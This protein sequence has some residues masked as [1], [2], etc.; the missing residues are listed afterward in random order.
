[1]SIRYRDEQPDPCRVKAL[2][3]Y[4]AAA[5]VCLS[6]LVS[7]WF[8]LGLVALAAWLVVVEVRA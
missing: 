5:L 3:L 6:F 7:A 2:D 8:V 1:V 4:L